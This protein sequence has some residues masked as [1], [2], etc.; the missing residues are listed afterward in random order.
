MGFSLLWNDG[1]I[2]EASEDFSYRLANN[3]ES[4]LE[5][6]ERQIKWCKSMADLRNRFQDIISLNGLTVAEI[7]FSS[8][9]AEYR[10]LCVVLPEEQVLFYYSTV[11]KKGS[12][13]ERELEIMRENAE[14]IKSYFSE[15]Y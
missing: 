11:P 3:L 7:R 8:M 14:A 12:Y 6:K 9:S 2:E 4:A 5:D 13:Q 10:A 15:K 1:Q